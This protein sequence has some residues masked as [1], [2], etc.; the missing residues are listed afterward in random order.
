MQPHK[1]P[2]TG[3]RAVPC[4]AFLFISTSSLVLT[5]WQGSMSFHCQPCHTKA[6]SCSSDHTYERQQSYQPWAQRQH[7]DTQAAPESY[8]DG[9]RSYQQQ[10]TQGAE[11][12]YNFSWCAS[13][14]LRAERNIIRDGRIAKSS[15][16]AL[17]AEPAALTFMGFNPPSSDAVVK[18]LIPLPRQ[19]MTEFPLSAE[20]NWQV[21][22]QSARQSERLLCADLY[23]SRTGRKI[24]QS[25]AEHFGDSVREQ[26]EP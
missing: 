1:T 8:Y 24:Q 12:L 10:Q 18:N 4:K 25:C 3:V 14:A 15:S 26:Q 22:L 7:P 16:Q 5:T 11:L 2:F 17:A 19:T 9:R 20:Q 23:P 21:S 6:N 13:E